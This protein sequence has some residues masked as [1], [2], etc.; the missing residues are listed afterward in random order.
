MGTGRFNNVLRQI[1]EIAATEQARAL[2]DRELLERVVAQRDEGAFAAIVERHGGLVLAVC[3]RILRNKHDAEDACQATFLVL[4]Q[5]AGT[6][7]K[8]ESLASWLYGVASR[9]AWKLH[10]DTRRRRAQA[11]EQ[12]EVA[13]PDVT[14]E[15]TWR[16]GLAVLD[17]ELSR[18]PATYRSAL[19]LCYLEGRRQDDAARELGCTLGALCARLARARECLRKRL[20]RRGVVLPATLVGVILVS[21]NA[22]AGLPVPLAA[23]TVKAAASVLG[24]QVLARVVPANIAALTERV[25]TTMS[26]T[27][28]TTIVGLILFLGF[29]TAAAATLTGAAGGEKNTRPAEEAAPVALAAAADKTGHGRSER[30]PDAKESNRVQIR[31]QVLDPDGKPVRGARVFALAGTGRVIQLPENFST[32]LTDETKTD[33]QGRFEL[34]ARA[35]EGEPPPPPV[36]PLSAICVLAEGHGAGLQ[37]VTAS[38]KTQPIVIR[39]P[40]EQVLRARFM[41]DT[42]GKPVEGLVVTVA[43]IATA[44]GIVGP[45]AQAREAWFPPVKTDAQGRLQ[46]RG[47]GQGQWVFVEWRDARFQAQRV[48]VWRTEEHRSGQ[49]VTYKL[50]P[51]LPESVSGRVVFKD[52]GKPA[53]GVSVRTRGDKTKT[54]GEG[55]FR[56]KPD[57]EL[58]TFLTAGGA[59]SEYNTM[60]SAP[61]EADA[62]AGTTY[63][64][65]R[66]DPQLGRI[67]R[68]DGTLGPW[69]LGELRISLPRGI[70]IRGRLVEAGTNKG[71]P[72]AS[73]RFGMY[74]TTSGPDG[75]FSM[76][77]S[78]GSGHLVVKATTEYAPV[79]AKV[80]GGRL[81]AHA[82]VGVDFKEGT[83]PTP[84]EI[85]LRRGAVVKGTLTGPN[86][87][88]VRGAVLISRLLI[89]QAMNVLL[90]SPSP[91]PSVPVSRDFE[92]K[93]CDPEKPYPVIFFQE[94]KRWGALVH[95][96]GKECGKPLDVRLQPCG[97]ARARFLTADGRPDVARR[98]GGDLLVVLAVSDTAF[99]ADFN[100][101][102]SLRK[103]WHT[104]GEGR[105]TWREL[106]PG[107]TY[108]VG[109]REFTVRPGETLDLGDLK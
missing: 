67:P 61:V 23:K 69:Q 87:E 86:G 28:A 81:L 109:N 99:W 65:G 6:I 38:T 77:T 92:L 5:K 106:V 85:S 97:A 1:R 47:I 107:V 11:V 105:V 70:Q 37:A 104:D 68:R 80:A 72:G 36:H 29:I 21:G 16:D 88:P 40:R 22:S 90:Q 102:S 49:E 19:V 3:R 79:E 30:G 17:E 62:P 33:A 64:G 20:L 12:A 100:E 59:T 108:R 15:I 50:I 52:T 94:E 53:A 7:R 14:G 74:Q 98:T 2:P 60:V 9:T 44:G 75:A 8:R 101:H 18:L 46:L 4:T 13:V 55:R 34:H 73:V 56:L 83:D 10:A 31:G 25:L 96:C 78:T 39:L 51:P 63:L 82:V 89:C 32:D 41:D 66:G 43:S 57:W 76:T 91:V 54:D 45:P 24:G 27:R 95:V 42:T 93:G 71:I 84:V 35:P 48:D 103:D 26:I 58:R